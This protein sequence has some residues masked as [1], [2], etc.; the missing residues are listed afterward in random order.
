M[1]IIPHRSE[2][3]SRG[4]AL[5]I[6]VIF[7]SVMLSFGLTLGSLGYKQQLL[8]SA[9]VQSQYAFY[10]ADAALECALYADNKTGNLQESLFAYENYDGTSKPITCDGSTVQVAQP[11]PPS[12][13]LVSTVKIPFDSGTRC[14]EITVY[15]PSISDPT[16]VTYIFS[17]GYDISC[18]ALASPNPPRF[19]SR[20]IDARY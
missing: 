13:F 1:A 12:A 10:V 9:A 6:A 4:F 14:A 20:G 2:E 3:G 18:T 19:V 17:Q 5:I 16:G 15:K 8:V 11:S 7:M